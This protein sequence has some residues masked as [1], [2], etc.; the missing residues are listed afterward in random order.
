MIPERAQVAIRDTLTIRSAGYPLEAVVVRPDGLVEHAHRE[1]AAGTRSA[2]T[3]SS[4][5]A[6]ATTPASVATSVSSRVGLDEH[7]RSAPPVPVPGTSYAAQ[8]RE[9]A[10]R[11]RDGG[12]HLGV[13]VRRGPGRPLASDLEQ[14]D[15]RRSRA[16]GPA[17]SS[18][19]GVGALLE[20]G[21]GPPSRPA[22][23]MP[24]AAGSQAAIAATEVKASSAAPAVGADHAHRRHVASL[25]RRRPSAGSSTSS[26]TA[27]SGTMSRRPSRACTRSRS[28]AAPSARARE[29]RGERGVG[30]AVVV[31][32]LGVGHG[33]AREA[34]L[35]VLLRPGHAA[36][37]R[38]C[39]RSRGTRRTTPW[40]SAA[41]LR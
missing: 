26:S 15:R 5:S 30:A 35:V 38:R 18:E 41:S 13:V 24:R 28:L 2:T 4:A 27:T 9:P 36:E 29:H 23:G 32:E 37:P 17:R 39:V 25:L 16:T 14:R 34:A 20:R 7:E 3:G 11:L 1:A 8:A 6:S 12:L 10:E 22:A 19:H 21:A 40:S 31:G 33:D